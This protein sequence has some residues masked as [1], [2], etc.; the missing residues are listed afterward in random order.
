MAQS[1]GPVAGKPKLVIV[2]TGWAGFE[3]T[4]NIDYNL[5]DVTVISPR[6]NTT[7]TPLLASAATGLFN[8]SL[9]E[10]PIRA[11]NRSQLRFIKA[12]VTDIDFKT[13]KC[14]C[15]P[16]FD[17]KKASGDKT[18]YSE[19]FTVPYDLVVICPG[20]RPNDFGTPGVA[21]HAV[22]MTNVSDA[23]K[24]RKK[25]FDLLEMASLPTVS[26]ER[27]KELLHIAIVGGGP[28]GIELTAELDDLCKHEIADV[29]PHVAPYIKISVYDVAPNILPIYDAKLHEYASSQLKK[30]GINVAPDTKIEEVDS[31]AFRIK[32]KGRV[33]YG[34]L[35][36]TTG[37]KNVELLDKLKVK[38]PE[39]PPKR[40][41][42]DA[43]L[44][45]Y[46]PNSDEIYDNVFALGDAADIQDSSL[47]TTAEVATQKAKYLVSK[48][49]NHS[50]SH[51]LNKTKSADSIASGQPFKF[52]EKRTVSYIGGQDGVASGNNSAEGDWTGGN[53]WLAWRGSNIMW[54]RTWRTRVAIILAW[55]MN[56]IFGK[57]IAKL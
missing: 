35:L 55:I 8:F 43:W 44:R 26:T 4:Q 11:K 57:E 34:M 25:L 19:K 32:G 21:E 49:N 27:A 1:K 12:S 6:R 9:A 14:S 18:L 20:V 13:Q 33:P 37:N 24:I 29:Y 53:A 16:A 5:Y 50:A 40:I 31:Q 52:K 41:Q 36:W 17:D 46:K 56:T 23:M 3:V 38:F 45:V 42:T 51:S 30:R 7:Y 39:K 48:L 22:F 2:G 28:T 47:P 54:A 15:L 10:E